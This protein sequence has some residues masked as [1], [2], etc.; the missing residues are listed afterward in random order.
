MS[1]DYKVYCAFPRDLS[2][3]SASRSDLASSLQV[4]W[5]IPWRTL[6]LKH[7]FRDI[8]W[9]RKW[10]SGIYILAWA[11]PFIGCQLPPPLAGS[12]SQE[13]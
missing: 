2:M 6:E 10:V 5:S 13:L 4:N 9:L 8:Y 12:Y 7:D 1:F 11:S 3:S